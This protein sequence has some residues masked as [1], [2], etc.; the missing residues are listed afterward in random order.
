VLARDLPL[1]WVVNPDD[2]RLA[3]SRL[4]LPERQSDLLAMMAVQDWDLRD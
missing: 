3:S 2:L 4:V 1:V